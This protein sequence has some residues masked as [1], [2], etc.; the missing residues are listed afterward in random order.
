V[1][2]QFSWWAYLLTQTG[3]EKAWLMVLGEGS[4][5]AF[6]LVFGLV[7]L[8]RGI[9]KERARLERERHMFMGVTHELKTPLAAVQLGVDTLRRVKLSAEDEALVLG[10]IQS[11]VKDLE[12]RVNDMLVATRLQGLSEVKAAPFSWDEAIR[13]VVERLGAHAQGRLTHSDVDREDLHVE[14]DRELWGL[15]VAN[16]IE[17]ALTHSK[18]QVQVD[19][20]CDGYLASVEVVDEGEGIAPVDREQAL[21]PFS[22]LTEEGEGTGLGLYLVAET[23]RAHGAQLEMEQKSKGGFSVRAV[24]PQRR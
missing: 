16:L 4:V 15:A 19:W 17:N 12:R 20:Q 3:G 7:R 8:E 23:V 6:F 9:K 10:N 21:K 11:G 14:G 1:L 13:S 24:W 22:R 5:F 18:G 2:L